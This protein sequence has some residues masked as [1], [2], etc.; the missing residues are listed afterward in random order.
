VTRRACLVAAFAAAA[1][2][3]ARAGAQA[4]APRLVRCGR[5]AR[6]AC[7]SVDLALHPEA[8]HALARTGDPGG[9]WRA[10]AGPAAAHGVRGA[11]LAESRPPLRLLVLVDVSG[12]MRGGGLQAA[13]SALRSFLAELPGGSVRAAVVPFSAARVASRVADARFVPASQAGAQVEALPAPDGDTG[14]YSAIELGLARLADERRAAGGAGWDALLVMTD[15]RN[16]VPH[17]ARHPG[18]DPGLLD[19]AAGRA[20]AAVAIRASSAYVFTVGLG[21]QLDSAE[22]RGFGQ[23]RGDAYVVQEDPVALRRA[24]AGVAGWLLTARRLLLPVGGSG[25][26]RLTGGPVTLEAVPGAGGASVRGP[27]WTPPLFALPA[28]QG[29]PPE[30]AAVVARPEPWL[31]RRGAVLAFFASVFLVLW[32]AVPPLLA[33][34][35]PPPAGESTFPATAPAL[36]EPAGAA[37]RPKI[38][39]RA[40]GAAAAALVGAPPDADG[41]RRDLREAPPRRP[42]DVTAAVSRP[43][44]RRP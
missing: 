14:L 2:L 6:A 31:L 24:L 21:T 15:G 13:R 9:T 19:G 18:N 4:D 25:E 29:R 30:G 32:T 3:P 10:A 42:S 11:V 1:L 38:R 23:A 35:A 26:A 16:D 27:T 37:P 5:T 20:R 8:A 22:L 7:L 43:L 36:G 28:F 34:G 40:P 41:L 33:A 12:S 39:L 44:A 17:D